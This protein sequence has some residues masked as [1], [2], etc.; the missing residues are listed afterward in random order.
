MANSP[1]NTLD[2]VLST[3]SEQMWEYLH[4]VKDLSVRFGE[5]TITDLLTLDIRRQGLRVTK[6]EQTSKLREAIQGTDFEWWI[7]HDQIGWVRF[8]VQAKKLNL[9]NQQYNFA[10]K[11]NGLRQL[12]ILEHYANGVGAIPLYCLYNYSDRVNPSR[13]WQCCKHPFRVE[14]LG[15]SVAP[16]STVRN[17]VRGGKNFNGV[18]SRKGTVPWRCLA[19]CPELR[20]LLWQPSTI[21]PQDPSRESSPFAFYRDSNAYQAYYPQLPAMLDAFRESERIGAIDSE[22]YSLNADYLVLP[23][24]TCILELSSDDIG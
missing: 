1:L 24:W 16:L 6:W 10:H 5:E 11:V 20:R 3:L 7:G 12:D 19:S 23:K 9:G 2:S 4:A 18:H 13:H 22:L 17:M 14:D 8:A 21:S 15:C